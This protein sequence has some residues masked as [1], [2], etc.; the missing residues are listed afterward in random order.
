MAGAQGIQSASQVTADD[1]AEASIS[2]D[3]FPTIL[4]PPDVAVL[5][6]LTEPVI[7]GDHSIPPIEVDRPL[8]LLPVLNR[9]PSL[10][11]G[12]ELVIGIVV[13]PNQDHRLTEVGG[14]DFLPLDHNEPT[15]GS[16]GKSATLI[17]V[18]EDMSAVAVLTEEVLIVRNPGNRGN[19][20]TRFNVKVLG[21]W[22]HFIP[23][24]PF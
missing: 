22:N 5:L 13:L 2:Q 19:H 15:I 11:L 14:I 8:V 1:E 23:Q 16:E 9:N 17:A 6:F 3:V 12:V 4:A 10:G 18:A 24:L 7:V 20:D 21:H